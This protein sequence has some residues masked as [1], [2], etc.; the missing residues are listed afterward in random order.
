MY[1]HTVTS[2]TH[3]KLKITLFKSYFSW[4][5]FAPSSVILKLLPLLPTTFGSSILHITS[6]LLTYRITEGDGHLNIDLM[7]LRVFEGLRKVTSK[8]LSSE[9]ILL[10]LLM[11]QSWSYDIATQL[12]STT[13]SCCSTHSF[14]T[15]P[16]CCS[17]CSFSTTPPSCST[18]S[19][20]TTPCCSTC[21]TCSE[22]CGLRLDLNKPPLLQSCRFPM[23]QSL[24]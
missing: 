4:I 11:C 15:T 16:P 8:S 1:K 19:F 17:T 13:P 2:I 5:V 12:F 14:S 3:M 18:G 21:S 6:F 22:L 20:S 9:S 24:Q 10:I 23:T 7:P